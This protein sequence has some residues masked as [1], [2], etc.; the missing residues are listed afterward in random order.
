MHD[1][2]QGL[3]SVTGEREVHG[4]LHAVDDGSLIKKRQVEGDAVESDN[5]VQRRPEGFDQFPPGLERA[6]LLQVK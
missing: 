5:K 4:R 3:A 1:V 6:L 2:E